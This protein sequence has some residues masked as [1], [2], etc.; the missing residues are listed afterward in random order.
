[1]N[2]KL[3]H[4]AEQMPHERSLTAGDSGTVLITP[5]TADLH[6]APRELM[7]LMS[8]WARVPSG[9]SRNTNE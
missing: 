9:S 4:V 7:E 2:G 6:G 8:P 1:M 3:L 5:I